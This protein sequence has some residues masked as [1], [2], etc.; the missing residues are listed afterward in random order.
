MVGVVAVQ[1]FINY[2]E[3]QVLSDMMN[4]N[5]SPNALD[6]EYIKKLR[7]GLKY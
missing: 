6:S 2:N 7:D 3:W 4:E 1:S 5:K